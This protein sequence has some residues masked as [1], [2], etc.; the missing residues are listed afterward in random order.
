MF[1]AFYYPHFSGRNSNSCKMRCG[2][3]YD[4]NMDCQ[5]DA[6]CSDYN[7]CCADASTFCGKTAYQTSGCLKSKRGSKEGGGSP[8]S[9]P[10]PIRHNLLL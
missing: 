3:D 5:C 7:D 8:G 4:M 10:R 6:G 9:S 1:T 2:D